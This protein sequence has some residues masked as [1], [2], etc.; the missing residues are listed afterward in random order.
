MAAL[1]GAGFATSGLR[2]PIRAITAAP[3]AFREMDKARRRSHGQFSRILPRRFAHYERF[4]QSVEP[5]ERYVGESSCPTASRPTLEAP[6][7]I[8]IPHSGPT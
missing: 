8:S 3:H 6:Y 2:E 7:P 5:W 4:G 1:E